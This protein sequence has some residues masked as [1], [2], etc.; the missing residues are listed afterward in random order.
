V[1]VVDDGSRDSTA[2]VVQQLQDHYPNLRLLRHEVNR[3]RGAARR[4]G[5]DAT[6]S[7]W[8]GFVD[9][10]IVVPSDWLNRCLEELSD[11][12]GV[13]GIAQ[14]DGDCAVIWRICKPTLR[15]RPGSAEI[16]GN[17]VV[18]SR[19]ALTRV[20]FSPD[21]RLGEDFR[22]AKSM[23]QSGLRLRTIE[24]LTVE[25]RE[26]KTYWRAISWMWQSGA[27]ATSLL[28][29]FQ[30]VRLPD[31][32][33]LTWSVGFLVVLAAAGFGALGLWLSVAIIAALTLVVDVLFICSRF[34]L[35]PHPMRFLG[36]LVLSP[37][38]MLAYLAG[39]SAG[40]LRVP[41]LLRHSTGASRT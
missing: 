30:V 22:L 23:V 32:A 10:D 7:P 17:N 20:P 39:R 2:N 8:V 38:M 37:P 18:F 27:D 6:E 36:A 5:Q 25:H 11:A 16:T 13:S 35:R 34:T 9:A 12:D 21:A 40:L 26:S 41:H 3:G 19:A 31:L 33:W 4:T 28:F 24:D 15:R 1:L 29:E 14:P